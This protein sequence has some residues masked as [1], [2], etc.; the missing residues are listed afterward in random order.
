MI[1]LLNASVVTVAMSF[2]VIVVGV[3]VAPISLVVYAKA[4][5][6]HFLW[7]MDPVLIETVINMS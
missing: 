5:S 1:H 6:H 4:V 3:C 7:L 2:K